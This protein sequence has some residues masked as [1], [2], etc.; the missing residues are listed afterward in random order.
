[1][2]TTPHLKTLNERA[3][4]VRLSISRPTTTKRDANA[5][6]HIQ[7]ALDDKGL[8]VNTTLFREH[9][10][11]VRQLLN[12]V[13]AVY[14]YHKTNTLP[15]Q[16]RGARLLPVDHYEQYRDAMRKLIDEV[17]TSRRSVM[18]DYAL[19]VANDM[20]LR[21]ARASLA[22]YPTAEE[23][24]AAL[25]LKIIPSPLPDTSH[26]L[27]D[28]HPDDL[29]A[30]NEAATRAADAVRADLLARMKAPLLSLIDKLAVPAGEPGAIFRDT[31][32]TNVA[33]AAALVKTLAMGDPEIIKAADDI[34]AATAVIAANPHTLRE[35]PE[36]RESSRAKL[37]AVAK[38]MDFMFGP[39]E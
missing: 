26:F 16:D 17:D 15:Y 5:E 31:K 28:V 10:S 27:F 8:R 14:Q 19:H 29:A 25:S 39:Q 18:P 23:F 21:G 13:T 11:P 22:D 32:V 1:M 9:T 20:T 12:A 3:M 34:L 7:A 37:A 35:S 30:M 33:D 38:S 2:N 24:E 36:I 4:L 6:A